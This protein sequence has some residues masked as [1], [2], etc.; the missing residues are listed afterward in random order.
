M[1]L[2]TFSNLL[3]FVATVAAHGYVDNVTVNGIL[4][5]VS[6]SISVRR[7]IKS[8]EVHSRVIK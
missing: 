7:E 1:H 6:F 2:K 8:D 4:Y 3:V 5:T